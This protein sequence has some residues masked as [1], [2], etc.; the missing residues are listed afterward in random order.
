MNQNLIHNIFYY[1]PGPCCCRLRAEPHQHDATP[2]AIVR[3]CRSEGRRANRNASNHRAAS[4][5]VHPSR[6]HICAHEQHEHPAPITV[7]YVVDWTS[8][9]FS[10][11]RQFCRTS[12]SFTTSQSRRWFGTWKRFDF[13]CIVVNA[14]TSECRFDVLAKLDEFRLFGA[15]QEKEEG[16]GKSLYKI[17]YKIISYINIPVFALHSF[18]VPLPEHFLEVPKLPKLVARSVRP[19]ISTRPASHL[20]CRHSM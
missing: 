20:H 9:D 6:T 3:H 7:D 19:V 16:M 1:F 2:A 12:A 10:E 5:T 17:K 15:R 14:T 13:Q 18:E 4:Q 8:A 11:R